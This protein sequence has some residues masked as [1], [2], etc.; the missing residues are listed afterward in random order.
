[1]LF[2]RKAEVRK[3]HHKLLACWNH[4]SVDSIPH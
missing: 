4:L 1:M 2:P 3:I